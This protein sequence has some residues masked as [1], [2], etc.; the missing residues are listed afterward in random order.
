MKFIKLSHVAAIILLSCYGL[1]AARKPEVTSLAYWAMIIFYAF[2]I[3]G[4]FKNKLWFI[5]ISLVPPLVAFILSAPMVIYNTIA[6]LTGHSLYQDSP[7]TILVVAVIAI[8]V[9]LPAFMVL[10]AYW[11]SRGLWLKQNT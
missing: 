6:F 8:M 1:L 9:T 3:A 5:R 11:K 10:V 7:A 2:I 4:I